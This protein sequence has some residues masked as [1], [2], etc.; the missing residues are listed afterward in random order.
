MKAPRDQGIV[1]AACRLFNGEVVEVR[2]RGA[3]ASGWPEALDLG[4][5]HPGALNTCAKCAA[6]TWAYFGATPFCRACALARWA[7]EHRE[8]YRAER[9]P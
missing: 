3:L 2:S 7:T 1:A 5:R 4:P 8:R 6:G 9:K